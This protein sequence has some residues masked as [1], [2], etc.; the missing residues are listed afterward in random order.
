[1]LLNR[2]AWCGLCG[3]CGKKASTHHSNNTAETEV[4]YIEDNSHFNHKQFNTHKEENSN[5]NTKRNSDLSQK[6]FQ[7]SENLNLSVMN[8]S[9]G[10]KVAILDAGAQYG[11]VIDRRVRELNI[12]TDILP[13]DTPVYTIREKGYR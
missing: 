6:R 12:E 13:L 9:I 2:L 7:L 3:W 8:G 1:M 4:D 11:K 10:E 5:R